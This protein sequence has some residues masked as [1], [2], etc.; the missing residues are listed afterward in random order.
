MRKKFRKT[1]AIVLIISL[2]FGIVT[3]V[4][5]NSETTEDAFI[6]AATQNI[7]SETLQGISEDNQN[8]I[9]SEVSYM[10]SLH[11]FEEADL[12]EIKIISAL[13]QVENPSEMVSYT[14][15]YGKYTEQII[16]TEMTEEVV[17]YT[18]IRDDIIN[19]IEDYSDG[20]LLLN[21]KGIEGTKTII[22]SQNKIIS[23]QFINTAIKSTV[24]TYENTSSDE[25]II[26]PRVSDKYYTEACPYG[27]SSDYTTLAYTEEQ[28]NYPLAVAFHNLTFTAFKTI[29]KKVNIFV[30]QLATLTERLYDFLVEEEPLS[31]GFSYKIY[32][33]YHKDCDALSSGYIDDLGL[34]VTK[35]ITSWFPKTYYQGT[36]TVTT[37]YEKYIIY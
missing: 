28:C 29:M 27:L 8:K 33:Y 36:G 12:T 17:A 4:F 21:G 2:M 30:W 23:E 26:I 9:K 18:V 15:N 3:P 10:N 6:S 5:A 16:F 14:I 35:D 7:I 20:R 11:L 13:D 32:H 24:S 25:N 31:Q 37:V 19:T 1:V 22:D 34:F